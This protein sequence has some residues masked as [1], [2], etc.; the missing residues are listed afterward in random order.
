M[1]LPLRKVQRKA[2]SADKRLRKRATDA[3][4]LVTRLTAHKAELERA[5][6]DPKIYEGDGK[7]AVDLGREAVAVQRELAAAEEI[8]LACQE[9]LEQ[10]AVSA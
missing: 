7:R 10:A 4:A 3:E 6:A 5:L 9:E 8:W 2:A 1:V